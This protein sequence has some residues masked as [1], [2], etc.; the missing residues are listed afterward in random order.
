MIG[1][2]KEE[3]D[4]FKTSVNAIHASQ[5]KSTNLLGLQ[6]SGLQKR[7]EAITR[8]FNWSTDTSWSCKSSLPFTFT[9]GVRGCCH[10]GQTGGSLFMGFT[11][12]EGPAC[13]LHFSCSILDAN[14]T[15]FRTVTHPDWSDNRHPPAATS[16]IGQATGTLF[17]LTEADKACAVRADGSIYLRMVVHL[18]L[19]V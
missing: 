17:K 15:V 10:N 5:A 6:I 3:T 13:T 4:R 14:G 9:D 2:H 12:Q 11:L 19:P 1:Q 16:P 7:A 8:V 18:Y